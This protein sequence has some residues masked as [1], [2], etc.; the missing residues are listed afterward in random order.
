MNENIKIS[1][2]IPCYNNEKTIIETL[3]SIE[4]Q[5][6]KNIEI[7]IVNDGSIDN[8][9]VVI[10]NYMAVNN[11]CILL[12][13]ENKG[14]SFSRNFGATK[15]SGK[16]IMFLDADDLVHQ[17]Y[18]NKCIAVL[19]NNSTIDIVYSE[20]E[21]FEAQTGKW[22]LNDFE[23]PSFLINN[24]IPICAVF[25]TE[26]FRSIGGF[27]TNLSFTEDWDLWIQIIKTNKIVFKIP[28]ILFYYRKRHSK[29][30]LSDNMN[31][32]SIS[33]KSRLYIYNKHYDF[34]KEN[35]LSLTDFFISYNIAIKYHNK[36][37]DTWY[38]KLFYNIKNR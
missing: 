38:R 10:E 26:L 28:E 20:I 9:K 1:I 35:N 4:N 34:Y 21:F 6:H 15:A 24:C 33:D 30:S 18:V 36:Y 8:S 3:D 12:N 14:P 31:V 19:E 27:D 2:V 11:N 37:F 29:D 16:Y 7:I 5:L 32:N 22:R 25:K 17:T 23:M 13:Q